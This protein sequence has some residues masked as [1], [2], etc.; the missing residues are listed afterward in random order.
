[1]KPGQIVLVDTVIVIE[2]VRTKSWNAL[3]T[4]FKLET[5]DKCCEEARSGDIYRAGYVTIDEPVL[6]KR[7]VSHPV[8][9]KQLLDLYMTWPGASGLD[10]GER[11][12]WAHALTRKDAWIATTADRAAFFGAC[13][14]GWREQMVSL[15]SLVEAAGARSAIKHLKPQF[16]KARLDQWAS[17]FALK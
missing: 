1:M 4:H 13:Q 6:R 8:S 5:V 10:D 12:L 2:A 7:L 17:E 14:L 11:H 15:E 9:E 3:A 16:S